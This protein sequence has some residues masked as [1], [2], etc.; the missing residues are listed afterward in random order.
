MKASDCGGCFRCGGQ[1]PELAGSAVVVRRLS[2]SAARGAFR[3]QRWNRVP[4][5]GRWSLKHCSAREVL[6]LQ[7]RPSS[8]KVSEAPKHHTIPGF[9]RAVPSPSLSLRQTTF[10]LPCFCSC[11]PALKCLP[12][13]IQ[14]GLQEPLRCFASCAHLLTARTTLLGH[15]S[16]A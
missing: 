3:D 6:L 15:C 4:C 11:P 9:A 12:S 2:C 5:T 1:A 8:A 7:F 10:M 16:P 14:A 13:T